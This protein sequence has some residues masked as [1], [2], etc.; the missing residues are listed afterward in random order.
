MSD[1]KPRIPPLP[2]DQ[3]TDPAREVFAFWGEPNSWEEGSKTNIIMVLA[4]HPAMAQA[5]NIW[6]RHLLM[7]NT[8]STRVLELL[9]LRV[10][11]R[12]KSAYEWHN[13]VGYGLN[14]G[15]TLEEIA[16][17]REFPAGEWDEQDRIGNARQIFR[18]PP[19]NGPRPFDRPL[20]DDELGAFGVRSGNRS[21]RGSDRIRFA[22][23]LRQDSRQ[24]LQARRNRGLDR[25]A[26]LLTLGG[27]PG[28]GASHQRYR[29][30]ASHYPDC[31]D[32]LLR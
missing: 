31:P 6:S 7:T 3:W 9:I 32:G 30:G 22:P 4:N 11:W 8:L 12:V 1:I 5:F 10:A 15:L 17:V 13:H 23:G 24:D 20:C 26:R 29:A 18:H 14:A 21:G 25:I 16:A 2:S 19:E 27:R 28:D